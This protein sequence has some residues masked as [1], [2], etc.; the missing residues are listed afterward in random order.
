MMPEGPILGRG[1]T[2]KTSVYVETSIPSYLAAL[3]SLDLL[4][5]THQQI[6]HTWWRAAPE[7]HDLYVSEVVRRE[8]RRGDPAT[9]AIRLQYVAGLPVLQ[10]NAKIRGLARLYLQRVGLAESA[11]TDMIHVAFASYFKIKYLVTWNCAHLAN[12]AVIFRLTEINLGIGRHMPYIVTPEE[13]LLPEWENE[14]EA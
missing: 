2:M 12:S 10:A 4:T 9:A 13:L 8:I 7:R 1:W 6:T 11:A 3:P 14:H 5:A